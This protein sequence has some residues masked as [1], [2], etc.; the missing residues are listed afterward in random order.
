MA[1]EQNSRARIKHDENVMPWTPWD[2][3]IYRWVSKRDCYERR[4]LKNEN[5]FEFSGIEQI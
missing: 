4:D 3:N 2:A 5:F 1:S